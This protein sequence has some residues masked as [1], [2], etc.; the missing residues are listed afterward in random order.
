MNNTQIENHTKPS[1]QYD[2]A[3]AEK[4]NPDQWFATLQQSEKS[5]LHNLVTKIREWEK[6]TEP[7]IDWDTLTV[8][9]DEGKRF[10][11][12]NSADAIC[13]RR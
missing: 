1:E 7:F 13:E 4:R 10:L 8:L 3:T 2:N 9:S 11:T 12:L 5:F 6:T